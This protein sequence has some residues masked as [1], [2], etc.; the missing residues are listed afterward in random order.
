M[1]HTKVRLKWTLVERPHF[2]ECYQILGL[3]VMRS[4]TH[5][6]MATKTIEKIARTIRN[7]VFLLTPF[8]ILSVDSGL[9]GLRFS[10][11]VSCDS[12]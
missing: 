11:T 9:Q 10:R 4:R 5:D 2:D 8:L 1:F 12:P 3:G 6:R 7:E